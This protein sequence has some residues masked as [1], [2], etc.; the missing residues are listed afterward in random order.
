MARHPLWKVFLLLTAAVGGAVFFSSKVESE[1][2]SLREI[3]APVS[4]Q[5]EIFAKTGSISGLLKES[6]PRLPDA[7]TAIFEKPERETATVPRSTEYTRSSSEPLELVSF[8]SSPMPAPS[9]SFDGLVNLNNVPIY[10][11]L[12]I[13]ADMTGD[14][15]P[16]H[17]VQAANALLRVF[18]KHG[19]PLTPPFRI[20]MLFQSLGTVCSTRNDGLPIVLYDALADRWLISQVCSAFPPFRQMIAV[21]AS[22]D[23]TGAYHAYEFVM[24]NVR[25]NDFPKFG[26]W[27][28]GYYM[29]T[30]E[31]LG[32]DYVGSGMFAFDREK[33]LNGDP[34]A[35]YVYFN[36]SDRSPIRRR[37]MLPSDLDGLRPPA[38]GS[39][40]I[41]ASYTATEYGE[42]NDAITLFDF[43]ADFINPLN[44]TFTERSESPITVPAFDP[45]SPDGRPDI[46]QPPPGERLDSQSDRLSYRLAYR[47]HG[48]TE[49]LIVAQTVRTTPPESSYRAGVRIYELRR[50]DD[51]FRVHFASTLG[52]TES[53]RWI[54]SAAQDHRSNIAF[55]YNFVSDEKRVSILYSGRLATDPQ[56]EFRAEAALIEGTGVQKAFGWRW[57]EYSGMN[58]D[59]ID[60]CTFWLTNGYYTRESE[61]ISDFAW[62]TRIGR[63]KFAECESAEVGQISGLVA[64]ATNGK[65][66]NSASITAASYSRH[67]DQA[68]NFG[69]LNVL[70]GTYQLAVYA[71]GYSSQTRSLTIT[72]GASTEN[73]LLEPVPVAVESGTSI[74]GESCSVNNAPEPGELITLNVSLSNEGQRDATNVVAEILPNPDLTDI[75]SPQTYGPMPIGS[76]PVTRPFTFRVSSK[77]DCGS[78]VN[79][80]VR[81]RDG[82]EE[83]E[84]IT[85]T[86]QTGTLV[87]AFSEN[88]DAITA[89][90]LPAG[91]TT[92]STNNHQ[93]WRTSTARPQSEPNALF[94]PAPIQAGINEVVSPVFQIRSPNAEVSF[95]HWY[96]LETTFLRNRLYDGSV[97]ELKIGDGEWSDILSAGGS[98]IT[99]GYDGTIDSCCSNPLGGRLG[100]SGR[101]GVNQVSEFIDSKAN[102]PASAASHSVR[103]RW[104]VG[105]DIGTFREGQYIDDLLVTDGYACSCKATPGRTTAFDF[106]GDGKSDFSLYNLNDQADRPDTRVL[107]SSDGTLSEFSFG[108]D[109]D[110]PVYADYDGDGKSDLAVFRPSEGVWFIL[111]SSDGVIEYVNFGISTDRPVPADFDGD[112]KADIAVF[113]ESDGVWYLLQSTAG[114][115]ALRFGSMGDIPVPADFDGDGSADIAVFRPSDGVWYVLG[116]TSGINVVPFGLAGDRPVA[117]DFD[118][119]RKADRVVF[120]PSQGI[121]YKLGSTEGFGLEF[122]G[123]AGDQPL[124]ADFDGDG[125]FDVALYRPADR[126]WYH[127]RSSDGGFRADQFGNVPEKPI[128][129]IFVQP[130]MP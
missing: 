36:I 66:I 3:S 60:D 16:D 14:V 83:L 33:M 104:R 53:S 88:F 101:S 67:T 47:N 82:L 71:P 7:N 127:L 78:L 112:G 46:A 8:G 34:T 102:L 31:F 90:A 28:D 5:A 12:I 13:P 27:T 120:R 93:F 79:L 15:G 2:D 80:V 121:W 98:F 84:N 63:F 89:P 62:L 6:V 29:S 19:E 17:Y 52:D 129:G 76:S 23:P 10:N 128:P 70:P 61:E 123:L 57:G 96:E 73:F 108:T 115:S 24:P 97:L 92:S 69:P 48:T 81:I 86:L 130:P 25:I 87:T 4:L 50:T 22:G 124:Q 21:S 40:N 45:T 64:D 125:R 20:S 107:S 85:V 42:A 117:G 103:L 116:S 9:A 72:G 43:Q 105:T 74:V 119:D 38:D 51:D 100:W 106:D 59:P 1:T 30:D 56:N 37:G 68:G 75:G 39:P 54:A 122:F 35:S 11:A 95:R 65:P 18:D 55:G 113:R 99:G 77:V 44:S 41:F 91:W 26:V 32:S 109:G 114:F 118:G 94:S 49:S 110:L 111:R 58:V 126:V